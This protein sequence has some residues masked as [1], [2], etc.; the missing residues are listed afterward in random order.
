MD[1][2]MPLISTLTTLLPFVA[3]AFWL[4]MAWDLT[5]NSSLS[6]REKV[7]WQLA[8]LFMNIFAAVFYYTTEYRR[9]L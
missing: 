1:W 9:K 4:W 5:R 7:Y 2:F 3:L 6:G 8:F